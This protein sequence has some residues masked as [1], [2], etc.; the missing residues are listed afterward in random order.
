MPFKWMYTI[1]RK[2]RVCG[3]KKVSELW[4][5]P[6]GLDYCSFRC[7]AI[8]LRFIYAFVALLLTMVL[9]LWIFLVDISTLSLPRF[10]LHKVSEHD[11]RFT[12]AAYQ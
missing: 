10:F 5:S 7:N 11:L 4:S 12:S 6:I 3:N 9:L 2:C 8:A 1:M